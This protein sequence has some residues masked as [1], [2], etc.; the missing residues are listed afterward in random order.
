MSSPNPLQSKGATQ[1]AFNQA[2]N[3]LFTRYS[4]DINTVPHTYM[5]FYENIFPSLQFPKEA[6]GLLE[7]SDNIEIEISKFI[8]I[9]KQFP[10]DF[11][12]LSALI[13]SNSQTNTIDSSESSLLRNYGI[14]NSR[15]FLISLYLSKV[16]LGKDYTWDQRTNRPI[17]GNNFYL[18]YALATQS[19]YTGSAIHLAYSVGLIYDILTLV[20]KNTLSSPSPV[21]N[22]IEKIF[23]QE[24]KAATIGHLLSKQLKDL[25]L[26]HF[27]FSACLFRGVGQIIHSIL[28]PTYIQFH[29][30]LT[31]DLLSHSVETSCENALFGVSSETF[32]SILCDVFPLF[33]PIKNLVY[34]L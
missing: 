31:G 2:E 27:A 17:N 28:N 18:K 12:K 24:L 10:N 6:L 1:H 20:A 14:E 29:T 32:A 9:I 33:K 3:A 26:S 11:E 13:K 15:N 19:K 30:K 7:F 4:N 5:A 22:F 16:S 25:S 8:K 21:V 23:K 34:F